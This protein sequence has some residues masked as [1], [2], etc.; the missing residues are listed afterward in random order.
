M[1]KTNHPPEP[2]VA[3]RLYALTRPYRRTVLAG[4]A[5][6]VLATAGGRVVEQGAPGMLLAEPGSRFSAMMRADSVFT[7]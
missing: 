5:C 3:R 1:P 4:M 7:G 6:L 2:D